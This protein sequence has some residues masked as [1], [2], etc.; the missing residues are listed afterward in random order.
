MDAIAFTRQSDGTFK[1]SGAITT[2]HGRFQWLKNDGSW[3]GGWAVAPLEKLIE[4]MAQGGPYKYSQYRILPDKT[5]T[6][7]RI[8]ASCQSCGLPAD[9]SKPFVNP[10]TGVTEY[11][12]KYIIDDYINEQVTIVEQRCD[13]PRLRDSDGQ[14]KITGVNAYFCGVACL[15]Q[16][17]LTYGRCAGCAKALPRKK[18]LRS[19]HLTYEGD[20]KL[21]YPKFAYCGKEC[22]LRFKNDRKHIWAANH[23]LIVLKSLGVTVVLDDTPV[24][25][26]LQPHLC[27]NKNCAMGLNR[28]RAR[29]IVKGEP[30]ST[31]CRAHL[32]MLERRAAKAAA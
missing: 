3:D 16:G 15:M 25:K 20:G 17:L 7:E 23:F 29:V 26:K 19:W 24:G 30:C 8:K 13:I 32:K 21:M 28:T 11:A 5:P 2:T 31:K 10:V 27:A 4:R 14:I 22:E 18:L 1:Q 9:I 6:M 12:C